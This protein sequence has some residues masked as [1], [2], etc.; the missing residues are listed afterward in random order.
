MNDNARRRA[1]AKDAIHEA[2]SWKGRGR[3]GREWS[4]LEQGKTDNWMNLQITRI[5][6]AEAKTIRSCMRTWQHWKVWRA[7]QGEDPLMSS[8]A[9][10]AAFLHAARSCA[11]IQ[12]ADPSAKNGASHQIP[13]HDVDCG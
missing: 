12:E 7:S 6:N 3:L 10:P 4:N 1:A 2:L 8:E 5:A 9:A 11:P 13:P